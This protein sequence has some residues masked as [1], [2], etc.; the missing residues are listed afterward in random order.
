ML[1]PVCER[2]ESLV[3]IVSE[4]KSEH[5]RMVGLVA[6]LRSNGERAQV[7]EFCA[8]LRNHV[9]R[10]EAVLFE[11]AQDLLSNEQLSEIGSKRQ[12]PP[13]EPVQPS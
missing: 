4:L 2:F 11:Q 12:T 1:F 8:T 5:S 6:G 3:D 10:E 7:L 9:R 13:R